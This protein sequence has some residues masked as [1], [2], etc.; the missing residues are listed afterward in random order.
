MSPM[1]VAQQFDLAVPARQPLWLSFAVLLEKQLWPELMA[2]FPL[3]WG[4]WRHLEATLVA[5]RG[6]SVAEQQSSVPVA[7]HG[8]EGSSAAP[9]PRSCV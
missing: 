4:F 3:L 2:C 1:G 8:V 6:A 9:S 5:V 7:A